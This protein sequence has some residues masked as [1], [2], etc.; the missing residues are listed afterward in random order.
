MLKKPKTSIDASMRYRISMALR[1]IYF[2]SSERKAVVERCETATPARKKDGTPKLRKG[3]QMFTRR[4]RC[5]VCGKDGLKISRQKIKGTG[6]KSGVKAKYEPAE[7]QIDHISPIGSM[8]GTRD[9]P[10]WWNWTHYITRMFMSREGLQGICHDCHT[11]KTLKDKE[12]IRSGKFYEIMAKVY[13]I[14][15]DK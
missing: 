13:G 10:K 5:E 11:S 9:A 14:K 7:F 4:Y 8:P 6:G 1:T 12:D 15:T 2:M 3:K